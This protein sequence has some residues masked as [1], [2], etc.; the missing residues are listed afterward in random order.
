MHMFCNI[1]TQS[2]YV[3]IAFLLKKYPEI[4][5][6][7]H[8]A[9]RS[10][11]LSQDHGNHVEVKPKKKKPEKAFALRR[12]WWVASVG[13]LM[14]RLVVVNWLGCSLW[15]AGI[16]WVYNVYNQSQGT[17]PVIQGMSRANVTVSLNSSDHENWVKKCRQL[18]VN[19]GDNRL[20]KESA[21]SYHKLKVPL[22]L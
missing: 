20:R 11:Y 6:Q 10:T 3:C 22:F 1:S 9:T 4:I 17:H 14:W 13:A 12:F 19:N 7:T 2:F 15:I 21:R 8:P 5:C 16:V 18:M